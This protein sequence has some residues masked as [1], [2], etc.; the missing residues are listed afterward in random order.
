MS[1]KGT[2]MP[3]MIAVEKQESDA[4]QT[5]NTNVKGENWPRGNC[6]GA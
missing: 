3:D 2:G 4:G 5:C 6:E 1:L